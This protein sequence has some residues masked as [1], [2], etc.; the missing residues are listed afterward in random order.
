MAA[1]IA[2]ETPRNVAQIETSGVRGRWGGGLAVTRRRNVTKTRSK[3]CIE[4]IIRKSRP[5]CEMETNKWMATTEER[6]MESLQ[7]SLR[8]GVM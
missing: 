7:S 5:K 4:V 3:L 6:V 8:I 1:R 2:E